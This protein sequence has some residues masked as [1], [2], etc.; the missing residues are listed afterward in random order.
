MTTT[1]PSHFGRQPC[2]TSQAFSNHDRPQP[3]PATP[4][5][6]PCSTF[7]AASMRPDDMTSRKA[8][9]TPA[10]KVLAP[11]RNDLTSV[12]PSQKETASTRPRARQRWMMLARSSSASTAG[13][14]TVHLRH[15]GR[16][17]MRDVSWAKKHCACIHTC[18]C[19]CVAP[20]AKSQ[21]HR[22]SP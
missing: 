12:E 5:P 1:P 11:S 13:V 3:R 14:I 19:T 10:F 20:A 22:P 15:G 21:Q 7:R 8:E 4:T 6:R 9:R 2:N 17:A 16:R 18:I